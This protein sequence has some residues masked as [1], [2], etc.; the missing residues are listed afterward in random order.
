MKKIAGR[1]ELDDAYIRLTSYMKFT[2]AE[3]EDFFIKY[4]KLCKDELE[5]NSDKELKEK[6]IKDISY[7]L[8]NSP[9]EKIKQYESL[10]NETRD[11]ISRLNRE[12][13]KLEL[14]I[15][16]IVNEIEKLNTK[17]TNAQF[18]N[19]NAQKIQNYIRLASDLGQ[20]NNEIQSFFI[21]STRE[22]LDCKIK[23]VFGK[24]TRKDYRVPVL[25]EDFELRITSTI[26]KDGEAEILSTGEGQITSLS[27]IG[28]LVSYSREKANSE[29]LSSFCGG[30]FPIVMDS[31]FGNLDEVHTSNVAAGIGNLASQ[32]IIIVSDKQWSNDVEENIYDRVGK[33]YKMV[34]GEFSGENSG[35][36]TEI[37]EVAL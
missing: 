33:M 21:K 7:D 26:K 10:R 23:E 16:G 28:S 11:E 4:H 19:S 22:N 17:L 15:K 3:K 13:G 29:L 9:L 31:P 24:I 6:R 2:E 1:T 34:D 35:E 25:T 27:F 30:D 20:L 37:K 5:I 8:S 36:Y 12:M 18:D 14:Q 32:V